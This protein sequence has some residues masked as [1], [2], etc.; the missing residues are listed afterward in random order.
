M[1]RSKVPNNNQKA[2]TILEDL[3]MEAYQSHVSFFSTNDACSTTKHVYT[4]AS[5]FKQLAKRAMLVCA[6]LILVMALTLIVCDALGLKLFNFSFNFKDGF[7]IVKSQDD[8][9]GKHFYKPQF[10]VEGY[11]FDTV[12]IQDKYTRFYIYSSDKDDSYYTVDEGLSKDTIRFID[13]E[14]YTNTEKT[15]GQYQLII[16]ESD[17]S[18][19]LKVYFE[20]DKTYVCISGDLTIELAQKIID[21]LKID[22]E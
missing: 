22:S 13:D 18:P 6:I 11:H 4:K 3:G 7:M 15:H 16:Y 20:K 14:G 2:D 10:I 5:S 12:H 21:S 17:S 19:K 8:E 9:N 1:R